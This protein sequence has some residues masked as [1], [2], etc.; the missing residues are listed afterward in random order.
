MLFIQ[1]K[2]S[3]SRD[4]WKG[5]FAPQDLENWS[6]ELQKA[7]DYDLE[8]AQA[9]DDGVFWMDY[10]DVVAHFQCLDVNWNPEMLPFHHTLHS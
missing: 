1:I 8:K 2:N 3:W 7:L 10:D 4:R 9:F 5:R 6:P